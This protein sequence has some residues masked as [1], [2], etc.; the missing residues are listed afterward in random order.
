M[1]AYYNQPKVGGDR[2]GWQPDMLSGRTSVAV[3]M[4]SGGLKHTAPES[5]NPTVNLA[6]GERQCKPKI[7][8]CSIP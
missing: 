7:L 6:P 1:L 5:Y 4:G 2:F 3:D 8:A